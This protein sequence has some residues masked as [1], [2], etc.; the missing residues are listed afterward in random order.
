MGFFGNSGGD[1]ISH[2]E[3][4]KALYHLKEHEGFSDHHIDKVKQ[5]FRGDMEESGVSKGIS[6]HELKKGIEWLKDHPNEHHLS[7]DH[8]EKLEE[9]L[10]HHL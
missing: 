9:K 4:D 5:I 8:I 1:H 3:L 6:S 7:S 10:R 2:H